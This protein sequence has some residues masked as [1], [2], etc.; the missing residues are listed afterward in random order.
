VDWTPDC[1]LFQVDGEPTYQVTRAMV[2]QYG[3]WVYDN[4]K[5]ILLN[6]ALGGAYPVK[7]NGIQSP[8][9]GMPESTVQL[10]KDDRA[11]VL[12][13]WVRVTKI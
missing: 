8:Y 10:I 2:Q 5:F 9:L 1:L 7:I 4:S 13:D 12:I 3:P 11:K 6:C